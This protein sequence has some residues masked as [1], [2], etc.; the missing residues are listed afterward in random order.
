M[1]K[2]KLGYFLI[3]NNLPNPPSPERIQ[4]EIAIHVC[5]LKLFQIRM[6]YF[7]FSIWVMVTWTFSIFLN[8]DSERIFVFK[9]EKQ[10]WGIADL[11]FLILMLRVLYK[12]EIKSKI[13]I[14]SAQT[15]FYYSNDWKCLKNDNY[16]RYCKLN[17]LL[18]I[19]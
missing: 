18:L 15:L 12:L 4:N 19:N 17:M 6:K 11:I 1:P 9:F 8:T 5:L 7:L 2:V 13:E 14:K 16:I 10:T 3:N